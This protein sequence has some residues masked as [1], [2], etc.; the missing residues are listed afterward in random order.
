MTK[1]KD[2]V[3]KD[4]DAVILVAGYVG[5]DIYEALKQH[6]KETERSKSWVVRRAIAEYLE[7]HKED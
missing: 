3:N 1:A 2:A 5:Y 7:R 4:K 6:C